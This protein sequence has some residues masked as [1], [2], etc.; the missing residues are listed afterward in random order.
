MPL[1]VA[2]RED[3]C[4]V[5]MGDVA[6][7]VVVHCMLAILLLSQEKTPRGGIKGKRPNVS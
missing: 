1:D 2:S 5:R 7:N 4:R 6:E 3:V